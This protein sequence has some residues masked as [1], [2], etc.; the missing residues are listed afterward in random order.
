MLEYRKQGCERRARRLRV[1][2]VSRGLQISP[3]ARPEF[4]FDHV[5]AILRRAVV[6]G[7]EHVGDLAVDDP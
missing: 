1:V 7:R 4:T 3:P 6:L 5:D 2:A